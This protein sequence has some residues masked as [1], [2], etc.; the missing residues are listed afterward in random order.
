MMYTNSQNIT[1]KNTF[2]NNNVENQDFAFGFIYQLV[3][4]HLPTIWILFSFIKA[5]VS[6]RTKW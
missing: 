3:S 4:L 2:D 5:L 6:E 1:I